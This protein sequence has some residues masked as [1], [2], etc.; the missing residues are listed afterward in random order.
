MRRR[1]STWPVVLLLGTLIAEAQTPAPPLLLP[2]PSHPAA[3]AATAHV[4][5][6]AGLLSVLAVA[7]DAADNVYLGGSA[8]DA[9]QLPG[10]ENVYGRQPSR[11]G[12]AFI[13]KFDRTGQPLWARFIGGG[14]QR[15]LGRL[16]D[17]DTVV[18]IAVDAGGQVYVAGDTASTD[19]PIVNGFQTS[20]TPGTVHDGFIAKISADGARL[21]YSSYLSGSDGSTV[22]GGIYV[23]ALG[24]AIVPAFVG[25]PRIAPTFDLSNGSGSVL[26]WK[27]NPAGAPLWISRLPLASVAGFA[28][29]SLGDVHLAGSCST[30][31][32]GGS[33]CNHTLLRLAASGNQLRYNTRIDLSAGRITSLAVAPSGRVA[34]AGIATGGLATRNAWQPE[35]AGGSDGFVVIAD[36]SG[37]ITTSSYFGGRG[38]EDGFR[39]VVA[40]TADEQ[41]VLSLNTTSLDLMTMR[42]LVDYHVDGPLYVSRERAFSWDTIGSSTLPSFATG[43]VFD[44]LR[45]GIMTFGA[46]G[47]WTSVDGGESWTQTIALPFGV[48][49]LDRVVFSRADA[50]IQYL[51]AGGNLYR[52]DSARSTIE[53][54]LRSVPGAYLRTLADN[55][56]DGSLWVSGNFGLEVSTDGGGTWSRRDAGLPQFPGPPARTQSPAT[57][58]FHPLSPQTIF[59][60]GQFGLYMSTN[61]GST[62]QPFPT[63]GGAIGPDITGIAFDPIAPN[64]MQLASR[65]L[66]VLRCEAAGLCSITLDASITLVA[67]DFM[68]RNV[69]HA[70]GLTREGRSRYWLSIDHGRSW[71]VAS[72]GL[73][74]RWQPASLL[75]DP[76]NSSHLY[77]TSSQVSNVAYIARFRPGPML[78]P[79]FASYLANGTVADIAVSPSGT[80]VLALNIG[81]LA[82]SGRIAV[83]RIG[84]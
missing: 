45:Q 20:A 26:V 33:L 59:V 53:L 64:V 23:S 17:P 14:D 29:D 2:S 49:P 73:T 70:A 55:P 1:F 21:L 71:H 56:H 83:V 48:G 31:V 63:V 39:P 79:E 41:L 11:A 5:G 15:Q 36:G 82:F 32:L 44:A 8:T 77:L 68:K 12:D 7:V 30:P 25:T 62:W 66:G 76:R 84:R 27:F 67:T 69:V 51:A 65:N 22:P 74:M 40:F 54:I 10:F 47:A 24:E 52:Y 46:G 18:G 9:V 38:S 81:Q 80:T 3:P 16:G 37:A 28:V 13:A 58:A 60:G 42:A 50:S 4:Y 19:F 61:G 78:E 75:L 35:R 72:D 34:V 57:I 43:L 6:E